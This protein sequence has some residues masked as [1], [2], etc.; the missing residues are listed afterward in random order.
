MKGGVRLK[1]GKDEK[2][3]RGKEKRKE[4]KQADRFRNQSF[5]QICTARRV[6]VRVCVCV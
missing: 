1:V 5:N 6:C 4:V 2:R 3:E